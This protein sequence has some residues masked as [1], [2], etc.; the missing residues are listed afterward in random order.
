MK[1][2]KCAIWEPIDLLL[3]LLS[4][5]SKLY[6][7]QD[8]KI[9]WDKSYPGSYGFPKPDRKEERER[10]TP[11]V[12]VKVRS[13]GQETPSTRTEARALLLEAKGCN[14]KEAELR[15]FLASSVPALLFTDSHWNL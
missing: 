7:P 2:G 11:K 1:E 10:A 13:D 9:H 3:C 12:T 15:E 5:N 14:A 8:G 4:T 6:A